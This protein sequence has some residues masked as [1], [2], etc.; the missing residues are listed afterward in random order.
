METTSRTDPAAM[1]VYL[2]QHPMSEVDD[3]GSELRSAWKELQATND[4][5]GREFL[6]ERIASLALEYHDFSDTEIGEDTH[7]YFEDLRQAREDYH[8]TAVRVGRFVAR[9]LES[10]DTLGRMK[11]HADDAK[12][13]KGPPPSPSHA[14]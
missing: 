11:E 12:D 7:E 3:E 8:L 4:P 10:H 14:N 2:G 5:D 9:M 1:W 13:P 6:L